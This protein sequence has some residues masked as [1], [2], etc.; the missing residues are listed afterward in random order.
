M[1]AEPLW[2]RWNGAAM[3]PMRPDAASAQFF[4]DGRYLLEAHQ[5][6][7]LARHKA[8]FAAINAAWH[9]LSEEA[10]ERYPSPE[11][12]RKSALIHTGWRDDRYIDCGSAEHARRMAT[13]VK[14]FDSFAVITTEGRILRVWTAQSQSF[15]AMGRTDFNR[16]MDDVLGWVSALIGVPRATLEAEGELA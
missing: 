8:Y 10:M 11:H 15:R 7:S 1:M 2:Y 16:S 13:F 3:V 5:E 4:C 12:L 6:R 14:P 9:S